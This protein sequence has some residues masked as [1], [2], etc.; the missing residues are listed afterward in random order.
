MANGEQIEG[1]G[2]KECS[3]A[4]SR[5]QKQ[6]SISICSKKSKWQ[7]SARFVERLCGVTHGGDCIYRRQSKVT[8]DMKETKYGGGWL[9]VDFEGKVRG[10]GKK[11]KTVATQGP[12]VVS[13]YLL[14]VLAD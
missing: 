3:E 4:W 1:R 9:I 2:T 10:R 6:C 13:V 8:Q 11:A 5:K 14:A 12:D 7:T